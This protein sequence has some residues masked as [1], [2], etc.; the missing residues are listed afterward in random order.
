MARDNSRNTEDSSNKAIMK[1]S[2][3]YQHPD[4]YPILSVSDLSQAAPNEPITSARTRELPAISPN[5]SL[6]PMTPFKHIFG[7]FFSKNPSEMMLP[8]SSSISKIF[9]QQIG[10]VRRNLGPSIQEKS[11]NPSIRMSH[12]DP[13]QKGLVLPEEKIVSPLHLEGHRRE[14]V[15]IFI[16]GIGG[17]KTPPLDS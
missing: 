7:N 3:Q 1:P 13:G 4:S 17:R 2:N 16:W 11:S 12:S 6:G 9:K 15:R 10:M 5:L 14:P 8:L